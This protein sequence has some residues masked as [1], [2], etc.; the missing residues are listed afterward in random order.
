VYNLN[1]IQYT[2]PYEPPPV[3]EQGSTSWLMWLLLFLIFL[4][5]VAYLVA[6]YWPDSRAGRTVLRVAAITRADKVYLWTK[7]QTT[8]IYGKVRRVVPSK[9]VVKAEVVEEGDTAGS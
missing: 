5:V 2:G 6:R 4:I 7:D 9:R 8:R 3:P 1:N